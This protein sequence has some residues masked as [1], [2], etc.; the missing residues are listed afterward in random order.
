MPCT[1]RGLKRKEKGG[2]LGGEEKKKKIKRSRR[3]QQAAEAIDR[4][5]TIT[6]KYQN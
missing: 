6:L 1:H 2:K 5:S 3:T 4:D